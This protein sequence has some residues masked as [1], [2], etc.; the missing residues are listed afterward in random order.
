MKYK[1]VRSGIKTIRQDDPEFL[2]STGMIITPRAGFEISLGC[3]KE[4]R[5]VIATCIDTG[6]LK[7]VA[8]V[9]ERDYIWEK[10]CD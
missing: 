3:P 2:L 7:P 1:G 8:H 9:L 5:E 4:Y 10:L 6:W